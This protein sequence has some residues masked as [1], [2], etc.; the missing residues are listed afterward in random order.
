MEILL[1][2]LVLFLVVQMVILRWIF[3]VDEYIRLLKQIQGELHEANARLWELQKL[4]G[5]TKNEA[6]NC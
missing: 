3:R 4:S 6:S 2:G 5:G 1:L